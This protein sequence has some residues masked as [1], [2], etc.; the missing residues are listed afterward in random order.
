MKVAGATQ[1]GV[2]HDG[3]RFGGMPCA[4][5][6]GDERGNGL[7]GQAADLDGARR[8]GLGALMA[9]VAIKAQ[10]AEACSETLFRMRPAGEDGDDQ[11]FGLRTDGRAPAPEALRRPFGVAAVRARH[12]SGVCSIAR[13]AIAALMH[14]NAFAAME[15]LDHPGGCPDIDLLADEGMRDGIEEALAL[16]VVIRRDPRQAPRH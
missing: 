1:I 5:V 10:D 16:D 11:P 6:G 2:F 15:Y 3:G 4:L 13:P 8:N 12:V 7:A 9:D 14:S